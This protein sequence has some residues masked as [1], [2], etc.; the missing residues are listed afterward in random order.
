VPTKGYT[1]TD[2]WYQVKVK[3]QKN[4]V[5]WANEKALFVGECTVCGDRQVIQG[6]SEDASSIC[7]NAPFETIDIFDDT[8]HGF[9][10]EAMK[11]ND[12]RS[13]LVDALLRVLPFDYIV[14]RLRHEITADDYEAVYAILRHVQGE[15][16]SLAKLNEEIER[17]RE[18]AL[19]FENNLYQE[20]SP[21]AEQHKGDFWE[22]GDDPEVSEF[23]SHVEQAQ[24]GPW[25]P[26]D[27]QH[28]TELL[29]E[30]MKEDL[31]DE[32]QEFIDE[33]I[34]F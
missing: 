3:N 33:V 20:L 25:R 8:A 12:Y 9:E 7:H 23:V 5:Q 22:D 21:Y 6:I 32:I 19:T 29:A 24:Y 31:D 27:K 16:E 17:L 28:R 13:L 11:T 2:K 4:Y 14:D 10:V 15:N 30:Q 34:E 26:F 1:T 18:I